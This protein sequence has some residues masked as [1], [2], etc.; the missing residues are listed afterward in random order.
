MKKTS[1][2]IIAVVI[3]LGVIAGRVFLT[4]TSKETGAKEVSV[5]IVDQ[6]ENILLDKTFNTDTETLE[7]FL[8]ELKDNNDI[9]LEYEDSTYGMYITGMGAED[10]VSEDEA[11]SLYWMFTSDTNEDCV[12]NDRYCP[13]ANETL[14]KDHDSYVFTLS[15]Y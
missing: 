14:I 12:K 3:L 4:E 10:V 9:A 6:D 15:Q 5:K 13:A 2:V 11:K 7:E 8:I 1:I